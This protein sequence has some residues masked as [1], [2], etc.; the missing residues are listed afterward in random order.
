MTKADAYAAAI[1]AAHAEWKAHYSNRALDKRTKAF[2]AQSDDISRRLDR[3]VEGYIRVTG[4]GR[5]AVLKK[6]GLIW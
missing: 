5:Y 3:A 2:R 1:E 4:A 6:F